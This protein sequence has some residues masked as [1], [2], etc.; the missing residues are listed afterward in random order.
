MKGNN[1]S[2]F[3]TSSSNYNQFQM[4]GKIS[5][6]GNI[7]SLLYENDFERRKCRWII[8][9]KIFSKTVVSEMAVSHGCNLKVCFS[10]FLQI[11]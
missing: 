8:P 7:M 11:L 3:S 6:S 2:G 10:P 4:T 9:K 5:A 1:S